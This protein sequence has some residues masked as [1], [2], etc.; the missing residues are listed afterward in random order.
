MLSAVDHQPTAE[1]SPVVAELSVVAHRAGV[2][3]VALE[4]AEGARRLT[5]RVTGFLLSEKIGAGVH[6]PHEETMALFL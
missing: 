3:V 1:L 2:A 4:A 6:F 5:R